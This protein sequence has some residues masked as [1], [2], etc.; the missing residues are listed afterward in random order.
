M[1]DGFTPKPIASGGGNG[2][3]VVLLLAL[4]LWSWGLG[5]LYLH[6]FLRFLLVFLALPFLTVYSCGVIIQSVPHADPQTSYFGHYYG[7]I[8]SDTL[9]QSPAEIR[10]EKERSVVFGLFVLAGVLVV[11]ADTR[12]FVLADEDSG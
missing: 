5:Y 8:S 1:A 2:D 3:W 9:T 10:A 6:R 11:V 4:S 12:W 7:A